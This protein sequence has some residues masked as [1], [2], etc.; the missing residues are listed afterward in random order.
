MSKLK[1]RAAY[2]TGCGVIFPKMHIMM[3]HRRTH[4]CGGV[5]LPPQERE[6]LNRLRLAREAQLRRERE[7]SKIQREI[8]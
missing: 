8:G 3:D 7:L 1:P 6:F 5:Y 4:R 2:C